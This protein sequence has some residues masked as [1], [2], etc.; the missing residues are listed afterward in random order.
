MNLVN[1]NEVTKCLNILL[2]NNSKSNNYVIKSKQDVKI[3]DLINFLNDNLQK[4]IKVNW[5][6]DA[7]NYKIIKFKNLLKKDNNINKEILKLFNENNK[8]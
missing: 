3:F 4:K 1:I 8:N 6:K 2:K 5:L 7:K